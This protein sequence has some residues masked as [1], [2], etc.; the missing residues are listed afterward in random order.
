M[1][2]ILRHWG[3][4]Y[5]TSFHFYPTNGLYV[6]EFVTVSPFQLSL[7]CLWAG[8]GLTRKH[9]WKC[10]PGI[11]TDLLGS[12][13]SYEEREELW[14]WP[15]ITMILKHLKLAHLQGQRQQRCSQSLPS[16]APWAIRRKTRINPLLWLCP[17]SQ[18]KDNFG[19]CCWWFR[20]RQ[21]YQ[22]CN[23]KWTLV[24]WLAAPNQG[25]VQGILKGEESLYHWPPVWLVWNWLQD[26]WQFLF[27]FGK[28]T[29]PNQSNRR[30]TEQWYFPH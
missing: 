30:S 20:W 8:S 7:Y 5:G 13:L 10:L 3:C 11:S 12:F 25:S 28:Q 29:N 9:Q 16:L 22:L 24:R 26:N 18:G 2:T 6:Q 15:V 1:L 23:C 17:R 27:L 4:I 19:H 21:R 14:M